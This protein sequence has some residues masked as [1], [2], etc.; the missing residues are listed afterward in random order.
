M[1]QLATNIR[2]T[3]LHLL[4][5]LLAILHMIFIHL[6]QQAD[7]RILHMLIHLLQQADQRILRM[8]NHTTNNPT[9]KSHHT[10]NNPTCKSHHT[11]NNP[12]CKSHHTTNNPTCKNLN[13]ISH[14]ITNLMKL[15]R[16]L[17]PTSSLIQVSQRVVSHQYHCITHHTIRVLI[18][19]TSPS[20]PLPQAAIH[21]LHSTLQAA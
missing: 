3:P 5:L 19:P 15:P 20:Q 10:T 14:I 12:T 17:I 4:T 9:C 18:L 6:L 2:Q 16:T 8:L 21:Q 13:H 1:T 11:T 7:Q